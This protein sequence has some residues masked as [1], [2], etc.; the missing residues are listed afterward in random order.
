MSGREGAGG[1]LTPAQEAE[2]REILEGEL[3]KLER[4]LG[5]SEEALRPVELD[6]TAVGRLSRIDNIQNQGMVRELHGRE[7]SRLG[8][9]VGALKRLDAGQYGLCARCGGGIPFG[10][11]LVMPE[12]AEC[13]GCG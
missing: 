10:R 1:H 13:G 7:Q 2:L 4:S 8:A 6:Q 11:L 3:T 9:V 12:A 5:V